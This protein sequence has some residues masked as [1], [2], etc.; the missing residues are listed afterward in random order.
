MKSIT[1]SYLADSRREVT[2]YRPVVLC[3]LSN[4]Q[5]KTFKIDCLI[6]TGCDYCLAPRYIAQHFDY[7]VEQGSQLDIV[8]IGSE[9]LPAFFHEV[10]MK[11][12]GVTI[13]TR[14]GFGEFDTPILGQIGFLDQ[15]KEIRLRYPNFFQIKFK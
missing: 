7:D 1:F 13:D 14:F 3:E 9:K 12:A 15:I 8:G 11:I 6:D 2:L 5:G 4:K 10:R